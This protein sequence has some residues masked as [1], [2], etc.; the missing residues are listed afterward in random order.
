MPGRSHRGLRSEEFGEWYAKYLCSTDV[1][2][3]FLYWSTDCFDFSDL[4]LAAKHSN[5]H[6]IFVVRSSKDSSKLGLFFLY[7]D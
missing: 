7:S 2:T 3:W 6:Y 1:I 4:S 5:T